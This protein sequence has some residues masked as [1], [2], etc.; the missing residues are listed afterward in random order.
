MEEM[1]SS[2]LTTEHTDFNR[3]DLRTIA[4]LS[5]FRPLR[6]L[7]TCPICGDSHFDIDINT[8]NGGKP[9]EGQIHQCLEKHIADVIS[10]VEPVVK[11][12]TECSITPEFGG[13]T[14]YTLRER[15]MEDLI[16]RDGERSLISWKVLQWDNI[17]KSH[18]NGFLGYYDD[19]VRDV[20]KYVELERFKLIPGRLQNRNLRHIT[21]TELL[22]LDRWIQKR[23]RPLVIQAHR[24]NRRLIKKNTEEDV[25][26]VTEEAF[27]LYSENKPFPAIEELSSRL[28]GINPERASLLLSVAYP[29]TMLF[30]SDELHSWMGTES[31]ENQSSTPESRLKCFHRANETRLRIGVAAIDA[32]ISELRRENIVQP[33]SCKPI[34][35]GSFGRIYATPTPLGRG[36]KA[37]IAVKRIAPAPYFRQQRVLAEMLD[38][39]LLAKLFPDHFVQFYGWNEDEEGHLFAMEYIELGSLASYLTPSSNIWSVRDTKSV[40]R[41][42]LEGLAIMHK[43]CI[44]HRDL[45]PQNILVVSN[46]PGNI[47]VKISDFGV[48]KRCFR[49]RNT[50]FCTSIDSCAYEAPEVTRIWCEDRWTYERTWASYTEKVDLWSLGC[51]IFSMATREV[52]F[53][54]GAP[55]P[56]TRKHRKWLNKRLQDMS[57]GVT[58]KL[59]VRS[60]LQFE[61]SRRPSATEA[62]GSRWMTEVDTGSQSVWKRSLGPALHVLEEGTTKA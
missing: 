24:R 28:R 15:I 60:L 23:G 18:F 2:H 56:F 41:Q 43:Q 53:P 34:G 32:N 3:N 20:H 37:T 31:Q 47:M 52:L 12:N 21:K 50:I 59:F 16:L 30:L 1:L 26:K 42:I 57:L 54:G 22:N 33:A 40:I 55:R 10:S 49:R 4:C 35:K 36:K 6:P 7:D 58:G 62:L 39:V 19:H 13:I 46:E 51:I 44:A 14:E 9:G 45:K 17:S 5:S 25:I 8:T 11:P 27:N 29:K 38:S 61:P 48:S